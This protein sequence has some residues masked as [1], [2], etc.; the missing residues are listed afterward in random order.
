[1]TSLDHR[2]EAADAFE[3]LVAAPDLFLFLKHDDGMMISRLERTR[4]ALNLY[5]GHLRQLARV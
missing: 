4:E 3:A 1:M 2:G 5:A